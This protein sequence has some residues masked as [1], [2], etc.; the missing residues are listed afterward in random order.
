MGACISF[1]HTFIIIKQTCINMLT[2]LVVMFQDLLLIYQSSY[3]D[4][5]TSIVFVVIDHVVLHFHQIVIE[6]NKY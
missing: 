2:I 3:V 6:H 5:T 4:V 1:S